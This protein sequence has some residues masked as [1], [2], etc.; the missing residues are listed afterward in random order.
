[1]HFLEGNLTDMDVGKEK[2][3]RRYKYAIKYINQHS[4]FT[5]RCPVISESDPPAAIL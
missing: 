2:Q 4:G 1:M 3:H 5:R